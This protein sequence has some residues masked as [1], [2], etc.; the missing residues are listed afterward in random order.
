[1]EDSDVGRGA[2][3]VESYEAAEQGAAVVVEMAAL[4]LEVGWIRGL[5]LKDRKG[6]LN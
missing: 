1:M 3:T 5:E 4:E 6:T 2:A